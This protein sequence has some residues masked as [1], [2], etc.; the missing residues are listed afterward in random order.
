M[1]KNQVRMNINR[2][3]FYLLFPSHYQDAQLGVLRPVSLFLHRLIQPALGKWFWIV[4]AKSNL[5]RFRSAVEAQTAA[6][7][8]ADAAKS[9]PLSFAPLFRMQSDPSPAH[10]A[11][12]GLFLADVRSPFPAREV[13]VATI[14][15]FRFFAARNQPWR[16]QTAASWAD[17]L[18]AWFATAK[19]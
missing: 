16:S 11:R 19:T 14:P 9:T 18:P 2:Q 13:S 6:D 5:A 3:S 17:N 7:V 1:N 12:S 4:P 15:V 8:L 10:A